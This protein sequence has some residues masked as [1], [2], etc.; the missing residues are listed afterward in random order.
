MNI[1]R[2][3]AAAAARA[4]HLSHKSPADLPDCRARE[5][6]RGVRAGCAHACATENLLHDP[7]ATCAGVAELASRPFLRSFEHPNYGPPFGYA[8]KHHMCT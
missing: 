3:A 7:L 4:L 8:R 1:F 2:D 6:K 5:A